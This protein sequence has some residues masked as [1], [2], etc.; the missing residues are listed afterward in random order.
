MPVNVRRFCTAVSLVLFSFFAIISAQTQQASP[1]TQT[2]NANPIVAKAPTSAEVMR[3][4][5]SKAKALIAVRNYPAAAYELENIRRETSDPAVNGVVNVLLMNS[6]LE[7]G[8]YKR[9]GEL[10]KTSFDNYKR[11]NAHAESLYQAVAGQI[12]RG[13]RSQVERYRSF[14]LLVSDRNLPLEAVRD[15]E[16]MRAIVE[17]VAEQTKEFMAEPAKTATAAAL[18]EEATTT[19]AA[20][21]RDDYDAKRWRD[22]AADSREQMASANSVVKNAVDLKPIETPEPSAELVAAA[23]QPATPPVTSPVAPKTVEVSNMGT[24]PKQEPATPP[25]AQRPVRIV[26]GTPEPQPKKTNEKPAE[27][28]AA[29]PVI[30]GPVTVGPLVPYATRQQQPSYPATA[31]QMRASGAVRVEIVVDETGEVEE[32]TKISGHTLLQPAARDA[33]MKW[34]FRPFNRDGQAVKATGFV[35][36]NFSL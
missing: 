1:E 11:N 18:H 23:K 20:L 6:Y 16:A 12:V 14:G 3:E 17:T 21:A 4:R 9:A 25:A 32:I 2:P 22:A 27:T 8:D 31:R 24:E 30:T 15:I 35:V 33:I 28:P 13:A 19:R 34:R 29:T 5:I 10:L 26:G 36:F 7:Q